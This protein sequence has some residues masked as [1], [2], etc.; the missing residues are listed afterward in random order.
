MGMRLQRGPVPT[1]G[2]A[3]EPVALSAEKGRYH[4]NQFTRR[5]VL[6]AVMCAGSFGSAARRAGVDTQVAWRELQ[7][8][9]R[10]SAPAVKA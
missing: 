1:E 7:D 2:P 6:R 4:G 5:D 3:R 9:V 8:F 10:E